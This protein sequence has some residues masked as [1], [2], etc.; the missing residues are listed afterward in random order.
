[1]YK[2]CIFDLDGTLANTLYSIAGFSNRA[3]HECGYPE[4]EPERYRRI[5]GD[6]VVVQLQRMMDAVCPNGWTPEEEQNVRLLY[7]RYY[8]ADPMKD[9][10]TYPGM[11]QLLQALRANGLKT[12]VFSNKPDSWAQP[13]IEKL[14]P[15]GAFDAVRGKCDGVPRKPAPDGALLLAQTLGV[16]P[17]ECLYIGDTNTDMQTGAN[18]GMDTVGVLWG[19]R[20]R[21]E[22][23]AAH[24][25]AVAS[26]P[27]EVL[28]I[29][30]HGLQTGV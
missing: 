10:R 16:Q 28:Q 22:L 12:A 5:V 9:I 25:C 17:A 15:A 11:L 1:M 3:L 14:F 18:A 8:N 23:E 7:D 20:D 29:A 6:G 27:K 30:L 13:I 26:E 2:A 4:I 24:A 19:F 21:Q